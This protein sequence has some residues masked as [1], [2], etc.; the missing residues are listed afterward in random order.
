MEINTL[1]SI[2]TDLCGRTV[3]PVLE[4]HL[5]QYAVELEGLLQAVRTTAKKFPAELVPASVFSIKPFE[6]K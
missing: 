3:D 6:T 1:R 4:S 5:P 2:S